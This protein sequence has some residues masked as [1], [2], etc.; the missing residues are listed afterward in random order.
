M[1]ISNLNA[2]HIRVVQLK[3]IIQHILSLASLVFPLLLSALPQDLEVF[4]DFEDI[5]GEGEFFIG[6][7]PNRMKMIGF[8]VETLEDPSLLHSG[9]KAITL[10]PGVEGK[11]FMEKGI[12]EIEFYVAETTGAGKIEARGWTLQNPIDSISFLPQQ[13]YIITGLTTSIKPDSNP[14]LQRF[15]AVNEDDFINLTSSSSSSSGGG[16]FFAP[17][18]HTP[19]LHAYF[20]GI[21][22]IKFFNVAGKL[23]IDD[24]GFT[25]SSEPRNN[26]VYTHFGEFNPGG[27]DITVGSSPFSATFSN[28]FIGVAESGSIVG[29][30]RRRSPPWNWQ[31]LN[32]ETGTITFETPVAQVQ[33]YAAMVVERP[34]QVGATGE[35]DGTIEVFDTED[36]LLISIDDLQPDIA[37]QSF[38]PQIKLIA[39]E[40]EAVGGIAKITLSDKEHV[41]PLFSSTTIDDFGFTP[42]GAPG[43]EDISHTAQ[44]PFISV[45][46]VSQEI[47]SGATVRL[48]VTADGD[49]LSYQW[50]EGISGDTAN[51]IVG[52]TSNTYN[53]DPHTES[54]SYWAQVT[55]S[56]G[57][58]NS[59]TAV[60]TVAAPPVPLVLEGTGDIAGENIQHSNGNIFDQILLTGE[61]IQLQ[62]RPNQITRVSFMDEDEDIVQVEF[63]GIGTFTVT[64]DPATFLPPS[65]PP[66]YNQD[67]MYVTGKPS[68]VI[69][70]ADS[71]TFFSIFTV[72][73]INAV[74]QALFPEGQVYDA[75]ADVTLVEVINSTGIGGMQLSNTV[76]SG[77][78][79]KVGV[80]AR[81]V[82]IAVRLTIGD[83][84]ADGDAV[85]Y[86]LFG[87]GSFTVPAGNPGLRITGGDLEQTNSASIVVAESGSTTPGFET[88]ISQ[89]N[90]KSDNTPQPTQSINAILSN[91][92]GQEISVT[93]EEVVI[94]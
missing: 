17:S 29:P 71:S 9:N 39:S 2:V 43:F 52:A 86:L 75:E 62:A 68:V 72:G 55:G 44:G 13:Q 28:G 16:S 73:S 82:P 30:I 45:Q 65:L 64:L 3:L 23:V 84:D 32:G 4:T 47:Q 15:V 7:E 26:I 48:S 74:N 69:D 1:C 38:A 53:S 36:N 83:I 34:E 35:S 12:A 24:L 51:A 18:P 87:E 59:D 6:E 76:F 27:E 77:S 49:D 22:E 85:P 94:E 90:F 91:A 89:N 33:F 67:V 40:L 5:S 79:G 81:G 58:T 56:D 60:I 20:D 31:V 14:P 78:T 80:D 8:K 41:N 46:P 88:L 42:I 25:L 61:S 50:Y 11:I 10:G 66:R 19:P 54:V 21:V 92:D 63:S 70:G 37:P 93:V 57:I